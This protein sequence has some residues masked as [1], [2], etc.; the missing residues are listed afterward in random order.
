MSFAGLRVILVHLV[1]LEVK[2]IADHEDP[3]DLMAQ[4]DQKEI[5]GMM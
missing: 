2:E 3:R 1:I 4:G 5:L